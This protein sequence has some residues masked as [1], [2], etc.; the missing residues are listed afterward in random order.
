M[1]LH[2]LEDVPLYHDDAHR[3]GWPLFDWRFASPISYW[4]P[5]YDGHIVGALEMLLVLLRGLII[6]RSHVWI[7]AKLITGM[8]VGCYSL[9]W[10]YAWTVWG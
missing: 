8:V 5:R 10:I 9:F 6:V 3:H 4:D 1:L 2:A 7:G